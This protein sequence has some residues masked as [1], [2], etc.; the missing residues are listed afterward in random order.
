MK[1]Y[2]RLDLYIFLIAT[3]MLTSSLQGSFRGIE[4][5]VKLEEIISSEK[6]DFLRSTPTAIIYEDSIFGFEVLV[7]YHLSHESDTLA[8]GSYSI[9]VV[10]YEIDEIM[11]HY[12]EVVDC[13][14]QRYG[15]TL[16][17]GIFWWTEDSQYRDDVTNAFRFGEASFRN[18]W[19]GAGVHVILTLSNELNS[20]GVIHYRIVYE[21]GRTY[22][23]ASD[24]AK[25]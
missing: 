10:G 1:R 11:D 6:S 24:Q 19:Y 15:P 14:N 18:E 21:P 2:I 25:L 7:A 20:Q 8:M 4:F 22:D 13:M 5:G 9:S 16:K 12:M 3:V 23:R 17:K